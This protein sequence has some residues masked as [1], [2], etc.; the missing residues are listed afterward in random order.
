MI[1]TQGEHIDQ[2]E[3]LTPG[4]NARFEFWVSGYADHNANPIVRYL[5]DKARRAE[6]IV[7]ASEQ[8]LC[9]NETEFW[10]AMF[11]RKPVEGNYPY[12]SAACRPL[13]EAAQ[14][15]EKGWGWKLRAP[16]P[17]KEKYETGHVIETVHQYASV[18]QSI[19]SS[20]HVHDLPQEPVHYYFNYSTGWTPDIDQATLFTKDEIVIRT[21]VPLMISGSKALGIPDMKRTIKEIFCYTSSVMTVC[22][23]DTADQIV[24]HVMFI[25]RKEKKT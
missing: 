23:H 7:R 18:P 10:V 16:D 17:L 3:C 14:P 6:R 15:P 5:A 21:D 12:T 13:N 11:H 22:Y 1:H 25:S 20:S 9:L 2:L 19:F 4:C 8:H 24:G